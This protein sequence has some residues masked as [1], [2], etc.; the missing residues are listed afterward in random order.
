M[1]EIPC[2]FC[3]RPAQ[4]PDS[5]PFICEYCERMRAGGLICK[6]TIP[7]TAYTGLEECSN[8]YRPT[9]LF[10]PPDRILRASS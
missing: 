1:I 4:R 3:H 9:R 10:L 8:P 7:L 6:V 5:R 2:S